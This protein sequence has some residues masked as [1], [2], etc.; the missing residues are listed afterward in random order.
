MSTKAYAAA[1]VLVAAAL[2]FHAAQAGQMMCAE[3]SKLLADFKDAY[4]ETRSALGVTDSGEL[5]EVLVGPNG[6]WTML[7]TPPHGPACI[8]ATGQSWELP[9]Q[10]GEFG[11]SADPAEGRFFPMGWSPPPAAAP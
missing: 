7:V 6:T 10:A 8:V 5:L 11:V 9:R 3:H 4:K 2:P 1:V